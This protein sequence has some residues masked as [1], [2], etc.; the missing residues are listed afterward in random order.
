MLVCKEEDAVYAVG[1]VVA[2]DLACSPPLEARVWCKL[3][4]CLHAGVSLG[5]DVPGC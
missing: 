4:A 1:Y 3:A 5:F 2:G